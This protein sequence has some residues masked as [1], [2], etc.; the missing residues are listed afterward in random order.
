[1]LYRDENITQCRDDATAES[2]N[3]RA[4]GHQHELCCSSHCHTASQRGVLDMNLP[5][6]GKLHHFILSL[7]VNIFHLKIQCEMFQEAFLIAHFL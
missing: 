5:I 2:H 1:M 6:G 3:Q 4:V 7:Q